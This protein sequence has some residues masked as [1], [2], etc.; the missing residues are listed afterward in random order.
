M[1][2]SLNQ[3]LYEG[4]FDSSTLVS[5]VGVT[6]EDVPESPAYEVFQGLYDM[7]VEHDKAET[8]NLDQS[9]ADIMAKKERVFS[10]YHYEF[11]ENG[12]PAVDEETG[13]NKLF[14]GGETD[15]QRASRLTYEDNLEIAQKARQEAESQ[16]FKDS[17]DAR[18][19]EAQDAYAENASDPEVLQN[20]Q[21]VNEQISAEEYA[22]KMKQTE[23]DLLLNIDGLPDP[24][25][26]VETTTEVVDPETGEVTEQT[27]VSYTGTLS[28]FAESKFTGY[29][30]LVDQ[31]NEAEATSD[32]NQAITGFY[33][34]LSI[35]IQK[36]RSQL[37]D[38][39]GETGS[40]GTMNFEDLK[41]IVYNQISENSIL[42]IQ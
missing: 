7:Q 34:Q 1:Y 9:K 23:E 22:L 32:E 5:G 19:K 36:Q 18:Q 15:E 16:A 28:E 13:K 11:D 4:V 12:N 25:T 41:N 21:N 37:A 29:K 39:Q 40:A 30:N 33:Q 17:A 10:Q 42:D 26:K 2:P 24:S 38:I 14:E 6:A 27:E 35:F 31:N 20:L 8:D 3:P